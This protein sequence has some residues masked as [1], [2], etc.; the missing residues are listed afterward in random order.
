MDRYTVAEDVEYGGGAADSDT[1]TTN[2]AG[3]TH[4]TSRG[5]VHI[6]D[7]DDDVRPGDQGSMDNRNSTT[8]NTTPAVFPPLIPPM[9]SGGMFRNSRLAIPYNGPFGGFLLPPRMPY[10]VI[11]PPARMRVG[12]PGGGAWYYS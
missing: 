12:G 6:S 7:A 9:Y 2:G 10:N 1:G 8:R 4:N 5:T 11:T 3:P